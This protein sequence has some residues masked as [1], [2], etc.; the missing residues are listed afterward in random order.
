MRK[1]INLTIDWHYTMAWLTA[2]L[3]KHTGAYP[4]ADNDARTARL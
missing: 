2:S 3:L 4:H 1:R